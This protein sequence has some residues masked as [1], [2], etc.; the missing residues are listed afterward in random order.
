MKI[1]GVIFDLD[2]VICSTDNFHYLAWKA[3]ADQEGIP[4]DRAYNNKL[5]GVSRVDSLEL[6]LKRICRVYTP[7]EKAKLCD[8]KNALYRSYLNQ[9]KPSD[10]SA[11]VLH[12]LSALKAK[13][14]PIAIGSS[15]KN[16]Q[17]ILTKIG[18]D[19]AFDAVADGTEITHSKPDPEV[20]LLAAKKIGQDP[21]DCL[22]IEDAKNG[23]LAANK[24]GFVSCGIGDAA[25]CGL[26]AYPLHKI[27]DI[28]ALID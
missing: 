15:S 27:S 21:Q 4:F 23:I 28:L 14:I 24:G 12:T 8:Q 9:M 1:K 17:L 5:R 19:K 20:F 2:G 16:T 18:L 26:A 3:I 10:V 11:D 6:I 22:V 25:T 13:K 7:E